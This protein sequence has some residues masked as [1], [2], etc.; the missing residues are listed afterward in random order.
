MQVP[1]TGG[2]QEGAQADA[3]SA[4]TFCCLCFVCDARDCGGGGVDVTIQ[5]AT[6]IT[7]CGGDYH[8]GVP[9]VQVLDR[10]GTVRYGTVRTYGKRKKNISCGSYTVTVYLLSSQKC[11]RYNLKKTGTNGTHSQFL[12][13]GQSDELQNAVR[14]VEIVLY[15]TAQKPGMVP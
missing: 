3:R 11:G 12:V 7:Q 8:Q 1:C 14:L 5:G 9:L 6:T 2:K 15:S 4:C 10:Y 13:L